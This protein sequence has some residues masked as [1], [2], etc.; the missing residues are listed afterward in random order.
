VLLAIALVAGVVNTGAS[1]P[2]AVA[3]A[4]RPHRPRLQALHAEPD[5]VNGGRIVDKSGRQVLLRGVNVNALAEYWAGTDFP[6][7]FPLTTADADQLATIGW[8]T[9]RLLVSWS[10][11]EPRPGRY[12]E[13]YLDQVEA[14]VK[15]L[16]SRGI[17]TIIDLHQD[18][19]GP[20]L[21]A[22][23]DVVCPAGTSPALGWDGAPGWAT[24]DSGGLRCIPADIR[25]LNPDVLAAFNAFWQ[26]KPGP[27]AVG[28]RTRYVRMLGMLAGR[29]ARSETVA[30]Y[31]VMNE[32]NAFTPEQQAALSDLYAQSLRTIRTAE[33]RRH[34]FSHL[35]FFEP[36]ALWSA[37]GQGPPP[38]FARDRHVVYSPHIYTGGFTGGPITGAAFQVALDEAR[39]FG[40]APVVTGE[41]GGGPERAGPGGDG[42]FL[43]HQ[44][45][46]DD[47][48]FGATLWTWR[49]SCGDPHKARAIRGGG[50][51]GVWGEFEVDCRTNTIVGPRQDLIADLTRAYPHAAPGVL[52][53]TTYDPATERFTAAG[54]DAARRR[55]LV[56]F[57]PSIPT[58]D[59]ITVTGLRHVQVLRGRGGTAYITAETKGGAWT[60]DVPG[61]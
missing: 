44:A 30:G 27:G 8:N 20:T 25:E 56:V 33:R 60:I 10:R 22:P 61:T 13:R 1:P 39:L 4:R 15:L 51:P 47:F 53:E 29:F 31:D 9:V 59:S 37:T 6:T 50:V 54:I 32:P 41:W 7:T 19:W 43:A 26:D 38:D 14:A 35:L 49:E 45:L 34:G 23:D 36:S 57:H 24:L 16:G 17:Y 52:T 55:T 46:Q 18:A 21:A 11:V 48:R 28:I 42:Y 12:D 3:E 40:G 58:R 2:S 5:P